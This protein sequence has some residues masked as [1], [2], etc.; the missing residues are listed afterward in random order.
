MAYLPP[1]WEDDNRMG[2][3]FSAFPES[4]D[5]NPKH[6]DSKLQFWRSAIVHSCESYD[7]LILDVSVLKTRF[8]RNG[9]SPLGLGIVLKE[10]LN[11]GDIMSCEQ[12]LSS[13]YDTWGSWSYGMAKKTFW[14]SVGKVWPDNSELN[15]GLFMLAHVV[16]VCPENLL[17]K[18]NHGHT[19]WKFRLLC[20]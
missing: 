5:A 9:V 18:F 10:M 12:F 20:E 7:E 4:R 8:R 15:S 17:R 1:E 2:F 14:W 6:W 3:M 13:V 11:S 19:Q 16:K